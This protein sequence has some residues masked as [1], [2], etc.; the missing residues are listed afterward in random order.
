VCVCVFGYN[1]NTDVDTLFNSFL[2]NNLRI[3]YTSFTPCK[4][5]ETSNNHSWITPGIRISCRRKICLYLLTTD[6]DDVTLKNYYKQY[7]NVLTSV[8]KEAKHYLY[9]NQIINSTNK[10]NTT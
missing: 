5:I 2:D 8:I 1:G 9:N 3:F 6:S 10:I 7:C 4:I